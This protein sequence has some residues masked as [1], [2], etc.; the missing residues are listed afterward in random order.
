VCQLRATCLASCAVL[1]A[2]L[3]SVDLCC[4]LFGDW[5]NGEN[6]VTSHTTPKVGNNMFLVSFC[7]SGAELKEQGCKSATP[8]GPKPRL[9]TVTV[10]D[11]SVEAG[12]RTWCGGLSLNFPWLGVVKLPAGKTTVWKRAR[13]EAN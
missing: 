11:F 4:Q 5:Q 8:G 9:E 1:R 3:Q 13:L 7:K 12:V 2:K 10:S 6:E